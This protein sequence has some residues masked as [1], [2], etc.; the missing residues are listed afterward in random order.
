M[1]SPDKTDKTESIIFTLGYQ[2]LT[3]DGLALVLSER[4]VERLIDVRTSPWSR[5]PG[6]ARK[7]LEAR[8]SGP[9]DAVYEWRGNMLGGKGDAISGDAIEWLASQKGRLALLCME[10]DPCGCHRYWL[11]ARRLLALGME[12][13]HIHG[14]REYS[15]SELLE[16]CGELPPWQKQLHLGL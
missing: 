12:C 11:I 9:P 3:P 10:N 8:F 14:N 4:G 16:R 5:K 13:V 6:F 2:V 15:T 7:E 1:M